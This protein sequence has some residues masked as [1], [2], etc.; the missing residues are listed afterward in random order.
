V[1]YW[2]WD[3]NGRWIELLNPATWWRAELRWERFGASLD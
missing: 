2:S 1:L 3:F